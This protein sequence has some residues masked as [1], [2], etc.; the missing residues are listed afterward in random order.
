MPASFRQ[1]P[2]NLTAE[3]AIVTVT[4]AKYKALSGGRAAAADIKNECF[5]KGNLIYEIKQKII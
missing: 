3:P 1:P 4:G 2:A 5:L